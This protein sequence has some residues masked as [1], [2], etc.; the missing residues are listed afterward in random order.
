MRKYVTCLKFETSQALNRGEFESSREQWPILTIG[1]IHR[2]REYTGHVSEG[3]F[4]L[5][6]RCR[7]CQCAYLGS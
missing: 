4:V 3:A 5:P 1:E 7:S 2:G 6:H